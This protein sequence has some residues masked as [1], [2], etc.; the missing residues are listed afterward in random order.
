MIWG[1]LLSPSPNTLTT[2]LPP[3]VNYYGGLHGGVAATVAIRVA[4]ACA[5]TVVAE[6]KPLFLGE[7]SISY[8]SAASINAELVV[9]GTVLRSGRNITVVSIEIRLKQT[10]KLLY[11]AQATFYHLPPSKL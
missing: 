11:T 7:Q 5:R 3:F 2:V 10:E 8:L 6:E 1:S 4:T 9:D